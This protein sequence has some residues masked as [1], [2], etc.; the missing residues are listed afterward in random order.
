MRDRG[1]LM[2]VRLRLRSNVIIVA[3]VEVV[4][5]ICNAKQILNIHI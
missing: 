3:V 4:I 2:G 5:L 1:V